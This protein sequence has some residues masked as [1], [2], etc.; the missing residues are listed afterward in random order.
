MPEA[1]QTQT[2]R[3]ELGRLAVLCALTGVAITQPVLDVFGRSPETFLARNATSGWVWLF[4]LVIAAAPPAVLYAITF[5]AGRRSS[6]RDRVVDGVIAAAAGLA[7]FVVI[8]RLGAPLPAAFVAGLIGAGLIWT[9][10][11]RSGNLRRWLQVVAVLPA[12]ATVQFLFGSE[13]GEL[14]SGITTAPVVV[15]RAPAE[16]S[17]EGA[18]PEEPPPLASVLWI[19]LDELPTRSVVGADGQIDPVRFPNLAAFAD[20]STWYRNAT[21]VSGW[22]RSA[23]PSLLTGRNPTNQAPA[24]TSHPNN[25][26][27]ILAGSHHLTVS[28][29]LTDLCACGPAAVPPPSPTVAVDELEVEFPDPLP[30][31]PQ[32]QAEPTSFSGLL[33]DARSAWWSIATGDGAGDTFDDFT[34]EVVAITTTSTLPPPTTAPTT[35]VLE[36]LPAGT[37]AP[38][39]DDERQDR[40]QI[41]AQPDRFGAFVDALQPSDMPT[42]SFLH[43]VLP[44][45]PWQFWPDGSSY[46]EAAEASAV[47]TVRFEHEWDGLLNEQRHLLQASYADALLGRIL[48]TARSLPDYDDTMIIVSS[49]HGISFG[50]N[51][52]ARVLEDR[53]ASDIMWTPLLIRVPGQ[54]EASVDDS[55]VL[56]IDIV[57]TVLDVLGLV[58]PWEFDGAAIGSA[59]QQQRGTTKPYF[60]FTS[61]VVNKPDAVLEFDM[62]ELSD[63]ALA[64]RFPAISATDDDIAGLYSTLEGAPQLDDP[65]VTTQRADDSV[66]LDA[67]ASDTAIVSGEA[68]AGIAPDTVVVAGVDGLVAGW[69]PLFPR[70]DGD[71]GFA[72]LLPQRHVGADV[73]L[74]LFDPATGALISTQIG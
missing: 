73:E 54:T 32:P 62:D 14:R 42:F 48:E 44:H 56:S 43:L 8:G 6:R 69:S 50:E 10:Y 2:L 18:T 36:E 33:D 38:G 66:L 39:V 71:L 17:S 30:D 34:E 16:P 68:P 29:S 37:V 57:P 27:R 21:A 63:D 70:E 60:Q 72:I 65:F 41:V 15:E 7:T 11:R 35:S 23:V 64:P 4:A 22:T 59:A 19:V 3:R 9:R 45:H 58:P 49:D 25:I 31:P 12:I 5:V 74:A 1:P 20:E 46:P 61:F 52:L 53:Y 24:A 55:N 26:F 28:E 13:A 67:A 47:G 40:A 51:R